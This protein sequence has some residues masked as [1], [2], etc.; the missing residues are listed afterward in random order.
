MPTTATPRKAVKSITLTT[1]TAGAVIG[2]SIGQGT[3]L[4]TD[5]IV[6][7][8][9]ATYTTVP[10]QAAKYEDITIQLLDEGQTPPVV[11]PTPVTLAGTVVFSDGTNTKTLTL[12]AESYIITAVSYGSVDVDGDR[13]GTIDITLHKVGGDASISTGTVA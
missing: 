8:G 5:E 3:S 6:A 9:D 2:G 1:P 10:R 7:F 11:S 12:P 13:K 4:D